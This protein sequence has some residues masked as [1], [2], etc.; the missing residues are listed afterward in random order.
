MEKKKDVRNILLG[1]MVVA[2]LVMTVGYAAL[3]QNLTVNATATIAD[4]KWKVRI[5]D[6]EFD[7]DASTVSASSSTQSLD[8]AEA[9]EADGSTGAKFDVTL[10]APGD[11]A[12]YVVTVTNLGTIEA[13]LNQITDLTTINAAEPEDIKFTVTA[14]DDNAP[15][16]AANATHK[17]IIT[18]EWVSDSETIPE[19][20]EKT[21]TINFDYQQA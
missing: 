1:V 18:V 9:A 14:A 15:I 21:V 20:T 6:I 17:Y 4:A 8:P 16:L 12:V 11:K 2:L 5:T 19:V 10:G 3:S 13:E 7:E